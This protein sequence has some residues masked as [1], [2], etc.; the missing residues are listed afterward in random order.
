LDNVYQIA[1]GTKGIVL[2]LP[3]ARRWLVELPIPL[4]KAELACESPRLRIWERFFKLVGIAV[5]VQAFL[6][7]LL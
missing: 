1:V 5:L 7:A 2:P 6:L 3:D 4:D